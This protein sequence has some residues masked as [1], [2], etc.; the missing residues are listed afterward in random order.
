M[1]GAREELEI[2]PD[3]HVVVDAQHVG[4]EPDPGADL[5]NP[6]Q[7]VAADRCLARIRTGQGGQDAKQGRLPSPVGA[8]QPENLPFQQGQVQIR[9]GQRPPIA[10]G[11]GNRPHDGFTSWLGENRSL[12]RDPLKDRR[13]RVWPFSHENRTC[14]RGLR[15]VVQA[16]RRTRRAAH[17][18]PARDG[19]EHARPRPP[20]HTMSRA[21]TGPPGPGHSR[22]LESSARRGGRTGTP[23]EEGL[24]P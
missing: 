2:L 22:L 1:A 23:G 11:E 7:R 12:G 8:D 4:H 16:G 13:I 3:Q 17:R 18:S 21:P 15:F 14:D 9:Q 5:A 20:H 6:V 24:S 10:L 19:R